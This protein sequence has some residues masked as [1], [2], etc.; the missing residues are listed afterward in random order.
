MC[1]VE[2]NRGRRYDSDDDASSGSK[3][4][5]AAA[6]KPSVRYDSS[7]GEGAAPVTS[8]DKVSY[9][10]CNIVCFA[11]FKLEEVVYD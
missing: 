9:S 10:S 11:Q 7:D 3:D 4:S 2:K 1:L 5:P 6:T 8:T